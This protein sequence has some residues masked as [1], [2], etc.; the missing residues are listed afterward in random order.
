MGNVMVPD[1]HVVMGAGRM[2]WDPE[3]KRTKE[4][5]PYMILSVAVDRHY[6]DRNG[7]PKKDTTF[8]KGT[9]WGPS[10]EYAEK[11]L[12]KGAAILYE[13]SLTNREK[14]VEGGKPETTLEVRFLRVSPLEWPDDGK[15]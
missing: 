15:G 12:K 6:R 1:L 14:Q 3:L 7:E 2:C 5:S 13:G 9:L 8:I 4:G 11:S 10:A